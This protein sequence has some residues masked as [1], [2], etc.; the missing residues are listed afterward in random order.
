[1]L[2]MQAPVFYR[3]IDAQDYLELF[4]VSAVSS[5][6]LT[7]FY[8]YV[9]AYPQVGSGRLH[10][11][12]VLFGGFFMLTAIILQLSLL[13]RRTQR[14]AAV[15]GGIGFGVFIDEL[16]KFITRDNN[17]F[18]RPTIGIIYAIFISLYLLFNFLSRTTKLSSVEYQLNAMMLLEE[19]VRQDLDRHE[20]Q[21][22][23]HLLSKADQTSVVT[24]ELLA[25]V[26]RLDT[27]PPTRPRRF[28]RTIQKLDQ[29]YRRFWRQRGSRRLVGVFFIVEA[30]LFL[31][32][33]I[34]NIANNYD[35][36]LDVLRGH[37]MYGHSLLIGQLLSSVIATGFAASGAFK[38]RTSRES[39]FEDF[40]RATLVNLFLTE[41]FIFSR[42]QF[43]A[44]PSFT[45]NV[46]LLIA[47]RYAL[48]QESHHANDPI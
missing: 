26:R 17:Y 5:L 21:R 13:G 3:N 44:I 7:R 36:T 14:T 15:L 10:I 39:A 19:A 28:S 32:L 35:A 22:I 1:M 11:A 40:R 42:I 34:A 24:V 23:L 27:V 37:Q 33:V 16:G 8:L 45:L 41:F 31:V 48:H 30:A 29:M 38:L 2:I 46:L 20:K 43:G 6:L 18:F 12:H 25:M 9:A 47:L 4:L